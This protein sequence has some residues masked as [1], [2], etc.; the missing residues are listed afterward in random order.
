MEDKRVED[1]SKAIQGLAAAIVSLAVA[2]SVAYETGYF[3]IIGQKYQG[4]LSAA[5]YLSS[6]LEWLPWLS[7]L[8]GVGLLLA[9]ISALQITRMAV[10]IFSMRRRI[11]GLF[12][13][14]LLAAICLL[15]ALVPFYQVL[16]Y[17]PIATLPLVATLLFVQLPRIGGATSKLMALAASGIAVMFALYCSGVGHAHRDLSVIDNAYIIKSKTDK[18]AAQVLRVLQKGLLV[19][20][21]QD[22]KIDLVGWDEIERTSHL[23]WKSYD[24][25]W[26]EPLGCKFWAGLCQHQPA[27]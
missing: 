18:E 24:A 5:D 22:N 6:A 12:L 11:L 9:W 10:R 17:M 3:S 26:L 27:P 13:A 4:V 16:L 8:Y 20:Q 2:A 14:L 7:L 1:L 25:P 23:I 21:P 19:W 15:L